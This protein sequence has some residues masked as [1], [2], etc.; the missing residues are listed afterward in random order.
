VALF[1]PQAASISKFTG[2][3]KP[4]LDYP[5][6]ADG[7]TNYSEN[8]E[9]GI[10]GD[11]KT[12]QGSE[13]LY[14][15]FLIDTGASSV[16]AVI[17]V[18][19]NFGKQGLSQTLQV[20]C[21]GDSIYNYNSNTANAIR[22]DLSA[23]SETF[24]TFAQTSDPRSGSDDILLMSNGIDPIQLWNGSGTAILLSSFTSASGVPIAKYILTHKERVYAANVFDASDVDAPQKVMVSGFGTDGAANPHIF[25][26]SFFAGAVG[27]QGPI[28]GVKVLQDQI[29]IYTENSIWK[30][31]PGTGN[32]LD[33][34][35]LSEIQESIG[36]LA[37]LSLVD[38]GNFHLFLSKKG[39]YAFDGTTI[40]HVSPF[41]DTDIIDGSNQG[42]LK[43]AKATYDKTK[44]QYKIYYAGQ[45]STRNNKGLI[46]DLNL[47]IWL[48]PVTGRQVSYISTFEN[49]GGIETVIYG[50]Y[51]GFLYED[52]KGLADNVAFGQGATF[53]ATSISGQIIS[54][55]VSSVFSAS[56]IMGGDGLAG[57]VIRVIEGN[58]IGSVNV[59]E[60]NTSN[61][62]TIEGTFQSAPN[63]G[64][65]FTIGGIGAFWKSRDYSFGHEDVLKIFR[66]V[67]IRATESGN[68]NLVLTYFVD[69][70]EANRATTANVNMVNSGFAWGAA[71][72]LWGTVRWGGR[73][74]IVKKVNLRSTSDQSLLGNWLAL[75][76][77]TDRHNESF[78][79]RG[80]DIT[81]KPVGKR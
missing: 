21:A 35:A 5:D 42:Y 47:G 38:V 9:Y 53:S 56:N 75:Q 65:M 20:V 15:R 70:K 30:F 64:S 27:R 68:F 71:T 52:S 17:N 54:V 46:F 10:D 28:T 62:I 7:E 80:F 48:P 39:I 58:G 2:G 6:L 72:S 51:K 73:P 41:I 77:Q 81:L 44:N 63:S 1:L 31:T 79:L 67:R 13:R 43:F 55:D 49:T 50:D 32:N 78:Q 57:Q 12:R 16:G 34:G 24:Y 19:F 69:F 8:V 76:F 61:T 18:H 36:C 45:A 3:Y 14:N 33:T 23:N 59:I 25:R 37:P 74:T 40:K 11:L 22:T 29:I 60:S 26:D 66:D 4:V